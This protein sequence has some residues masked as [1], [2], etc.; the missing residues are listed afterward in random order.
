MASSSQVRELTARIGEERLPAAS[1]LPE[2]SLQ[3]YYREAGPDYAAWSSEFNMHFGYYR[4][5]ANPLRREAMLEQMN[6]EV[7][8]RLRLDEIANPQVLD[9]G[10]G[11][12]ATL[13]SV[14]RR[15]PGAK[16]FG[17]TCV[18]WQ[19]EQARALNKAAGCSDRISIIE[20]DYEDNLSMPSCGF[21]GVYALESSCHAHGPDKAALLREAHRLLRPGGRLVV[22][23]GFLARASFVGGLQERIYHKLCTCWVI[24]ELA[25][26]EL[27]TAQ[28]E[29]LDFRDITV[30]RLQFR[31]APSVMHVPWVTLKFLI[32]DVVFGKRPMTAARWNNVLAPVLLPLVSAPF[33]PMT[34]CMITATKT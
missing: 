4:A 6:A 34:Y 18:P 22:A 16:L 14:A 13:R 32:T 12:G 21:D 10:C 27:F 1:V 5:G 26:L 7:L 29:Q 31:V 19:V 33:G 2:I 30:E 24:E 17:I 20:G 23:D 28:L 25:Q 8:A 3:R 15:R 11:L 9:L